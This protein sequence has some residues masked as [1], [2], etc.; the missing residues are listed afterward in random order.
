MSDKKEILS[1][2]MIYNQRKINDKMENNF[3][4]YVFHAWQGLLQT[5][6]YFTID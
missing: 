6:N 3:Y 5:N 2:D 1:K 4:V